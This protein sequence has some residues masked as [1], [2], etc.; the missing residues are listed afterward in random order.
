MSVYLKRIVRARQ[1]LVDAE[2]SL[3]EALPD[4]LEKVG[5]DMP[6]S[7]I[8]SETRYGRNDNIK[9]VTEYSVETDG[10]KPTL[11]FHFKGKRLGD[12]LSRDFIPFSTFP[13]DLDSKSLMQAAKAL[14][15]LGY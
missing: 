3:R 2:R 1:E 6:H 9:I 11:Y 14:K 12:P 7:V 8:C 5:K 13:S 15:A 4:L 10:I